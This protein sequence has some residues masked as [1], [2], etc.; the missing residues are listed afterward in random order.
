MTKSNRLIFI[1]GIMLFNPVIT[2]LDPLPDAI[3]FL[4]IA[5]GL[6]PYSKVEMALDDARRNAFFMVGIGTVKL[7]L[8]PVVMSSLYADDKLLAAAGFAIIECIFGSMFMNNFF[9]GMSYLAVRHGDGTLTARYSE[10]TAFIKMFFQL[11]IWLSVIPE[12][13]ALAADAAHDNKDHYD[14]LMIIAGMKNIL[15]LLTV[16]TVLAVGVIYLI[17]IRKIYVA[18]RAE[19]Q[20]S[21]HIYE[22]YRS[23]YI[24]ND[25]KRLKRRFGAANIILTVGVACFIGLTIDDVPVLAPAYGMLLS[26]VALTVIGGDRKHFGGVFI[27]AL[28]AAAEFAAELLRIN[29]VDANIIDIL[30]ITPQVV[31]NGVLI[32]LLSAAA[33]I[34]FAKIFIS[35]YRS[36]VKKQLGR[37]VA[38]T[39]VFICGVVMLLIRSAENILPNIR[40]WVPTVYAVIA[41]I[42]AV[43]AANRFF[44][45]CREE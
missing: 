9:S 20:L 44:G 19:T 30:Q 2:V 27:I 11:R 13:T 39:S 3:G 29:A 36:A 18:S 24:T 40:M 21:E 35:T 26:A 38:F 8:T 37:D 32:S 23:K 15:I 16:A 17:K 10:D 22:I 34:V 5:I 7:L 41:I 45:T 31:I 43:M 14:D 6:F 25:L 12:L 4:L 33:W 28:C 42:F 1:G